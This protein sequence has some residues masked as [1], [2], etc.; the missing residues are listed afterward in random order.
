MSLLTRRQRD[1]SDSTGCNVNK[2][3]FEP[4]RTTDG[5][6]AYYVFYEGAQP[7]H[8]PYRANTIANVL[9]AALREI[10]GLPDE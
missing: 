10:E 1:T 4:V 8:G 2:I 7:P 9:A 6:L 5:H 3:I